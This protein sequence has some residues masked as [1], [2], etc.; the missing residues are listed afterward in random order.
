MSDLE[1]ESQTGGQSPKYKLTERAYLK[2]DG[3]QF[4]MLHEEGAEIEFRGVPGYH[5]Q[6]VNA[7][8]KRMVDKHKPQNFDFNKLAPLQAAA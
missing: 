8:A 6:P 4:E 5:M 1:N 2:A 3:D 7:A